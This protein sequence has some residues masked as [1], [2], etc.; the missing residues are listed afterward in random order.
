MVLIYHFAYLSFVPTYHFCELVTKSLKEIFMERRV[1]G[2]PALLLVTYS[3]MNK[4]LHEAFGC[5]AGKGVWS[6]SVK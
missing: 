1:G 4:D 5:F 2:V 3:G 6:K